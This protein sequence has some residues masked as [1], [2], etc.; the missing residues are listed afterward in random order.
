MARMMPPMLQVMK[1]VGGVEMPEYLAKLTGDAPKPTAV[2][3]AVNGQATPATAE[4]A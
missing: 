4:K 1:D 2:D 3:P